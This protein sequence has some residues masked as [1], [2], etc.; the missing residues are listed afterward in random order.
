MSDLKLNPMRAWNKRCKKSMLPLAVAGAAVLAFAPLA[1][2][3]LEAVGGVD[4]AT[5][6]PLYYEDATG[7]RLS[8]CL[9]QDPAFCLPLVGGPDGIPFPGQPIG[10]NGPGTADDNFPLEAFYWSGEALMQTAGGGDA[11]LVLALEAAWFNEAVVDGDQ[12]VFGRIRYRIDNLIP[13]EMYRITTPFGVFTEV[14]EAAG[15]RGINTTEDIGI[16][17]GDFTAVLGAKVGPFLVPTGFDAATPTVVDGDGVGYIAA[18]GVE[19][20]VTG[21]VLEVNAAYGQGPGS[22]GPANFFRIEGRGVGNQPGLTGSPDRCASV[23]LGADLSGVNNRSDCVETNLFS[24]TGQIASVFG[25][26]PVRTT[27][28]RAANGNGRIDVLATSVPSTPTSPQI[29]EASIPGRSIPLLEDPI[30]SGRYFGRFSHNGLPLPGD[31]TLTNT[32]DIP[33]TEVT[34]P[35]V[36]SITVNRAVFITNGLVNPVDVT[37]PFGVP[38]GVTDDR[39]VVGTLELRVNSSD[40]D[41]ASA[42]DLFAL[43]SFGEPLLCTDPGTDGVIGG[44][45]DGATSE[46]IPDNVLV[47]CPVFAVGEITISSSAGGVGTQTVIIQ[48]SNVNANNGGL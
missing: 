34:A 14:A 18:A 42:P 10:F 30:G 5:G 1:Q 27:Y 28:T 19:T 44:G 39:D 35:L 41:A 33:P 24:L 38:D 26:K 17:Q 29:I 40:N 7:L 3:D 25:V 11:L 12:I 21:S 47:I 6:Y 31:L 32:T 8:L 46:V 22:P 43:N 9:N 16:V 45:D 23:A 37:G 2:A 36:D 13:G 15:R 20:T 4:P 48:G